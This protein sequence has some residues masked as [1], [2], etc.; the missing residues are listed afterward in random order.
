M[1][2]N[3]HCLLWLSSFPLSCSTLSLFMYPNHHFSTPS[4]NAIDVVNSSAPS[5]ISDTARVAPNQTPRCDAS[6]CTFSDSTCMS[7]MSHQWSSSNPPPGVA[8]GCAPDF[9]SAWNSS[10]ASMSHAFNLGYNMVAAWGGRPPSIG[11]AFPQGT[12]FAQR[13]AT[14]FQ[15]Q[16]P[17]FPSPVTLASVGP[18]P[19]CVSCGQAPRFTAPPTP[20]APPSYAPSHCGTSGTNLSGAPR[21]AAPNVCAPPGFGALSTPPRP[22]A[23]TIPGFPF[24]APPPSGFPFNPVKF[25]RTCRWS[26]SSCNAC[27]VAFNF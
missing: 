23:N 17:C 20:S 8:P 4:N 3:Y 25:L 12:L 26:S 10:P 27:F 13:A 15:N 18:G 16:G 9:S 2:Y 5:N 22:I 7:N 6:S 19:G 14:H 24:A 21:A 1:A 11:D